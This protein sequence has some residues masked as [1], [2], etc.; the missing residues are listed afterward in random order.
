MR[1]RSLLVIFSLMCLLFFALSGE[2]LPANPG[3]DRERG[4]NKN[5]AQEVKSVKN[6][7]RDITKK[8]NSGKTYIVKKGDTLF[9]ISRK[10]NVP[11]DD[12]KRINNLKDDNIKVGM[13]LRLENCSLISEGKALKGE[14][15]KKSKNYEHQRINEDNN[16]FDCK[17]LWPVKRIISYSRDGAEGVRALGIIIT[18]PESG[19][20]FASMDGVVDKIGYM[21]GY[22]RYIILKHD[23]RFITV[24]SNLETVFVKRGD[25]VKRGDSLGRVSSDGRVH[26]QIGKNG[27]PQ[28]PLKYLKERG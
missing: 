9:S 21:R 6:T 3:K 15:L 27:R 28:D 4:K 24:Y 16:D 26:F 5:N 25:R 12:I 7:Q 10:F 14:D 13:A 11:L 8:N 17:F 18:T 19:N 20:V 2:E 1:E 23:F 22:G